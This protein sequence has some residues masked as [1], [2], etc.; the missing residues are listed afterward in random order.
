MPSRRVVVGT[1]Y[2]LAMALVAAVAAWPIYRS[3]EYVAVAAAGTLLG[4]AIALAAA[5]LR[6]RGWLTALVT[7]AALLVSGVVLAVPAQRG[8]LAQV[9]AA[10]RD[11]LLGTVTGF[12]DLI[13]VELPVGSYRNLLVPALVVFL[14]GTVSALLLSWHRARIAVTGALVALAMVFF[15]LAFGRTETSAPFVWGWLVVPAPVEL[16]TGAAAIVLSV[17][18]LAW[19]ALDERRESLRRTAASTGVRVT[20]RRSASDL[21]RTALAVGMVAVAVVL[22]GIAAPA[23][24]AGQTRQVLRSGVG[25]ELDIARAP[26]PL[27]TY[28][29]NFEDP[30]YDQVLFRVESVDGP[31]PDRVRL[32]TMTAYDGAVY[33][34]LDGGSS[35]ADARFVR[36]PSRLDPGTGV[37]STVRVTID[38]LRGI[39]LPTVGRISSVAFE[40]TDAAQLA[41]GFYY[42]QGSAAAVE[43]SGGGVGAGDEYVVSAVAPHTPS[44]AAISAPGASGSAVAAPASLV[45]WVKQQ[46]V[47]TD[48]AALAELLARLRER[49]YL[50]HALAVADGDPPQWVTDL[51]EYAFRPSASGHSLARV[52]ALFRALLERAAQVQADGGRGSLVAAVGDDEQFAVAGALIAEQ[53]GFPARVVLGAR[54]SGDPQAGAMCQDGACRAGDLTAWIEVQASTGQ[55][56]AADVTPQHTEG[57]DTA[58]RRQRDPENPT[59]VR[60]E[61]AAEVV[62]PQPEQQDSGD[63]PHDGTGVDLS[64]LWATLRVGG[65]ALA[66]LALVL[67]PLA[68]V[69]AAKA[70]RRRARR[71]ESD[72]ASRVAGGWEEYVDA[73]VDHGLPAPRALTR[74]ELAEAHARPA[75]AGLAATADRAV[76]SDGPMSAQEADEFWRI[77]DAERRGLAAEVPV[78]RRLAA[79]VSLKSFTR[80]L[81]SRTGRG[82]AAAR[83]TERRR[84]RHDDAEQS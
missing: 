58:V 10:A 24:A 72:P 32:A 39:W 57:I 79:A 18:S 73:A 71:G 8:S 34:V 46:G 7:A 35:V 76:F 40:G 77:V 61:S 11:V 50:S 69:V 83:P 62:P 41:D 33:R 65:L 60:P 45:E 48:G 14:V 67:G 55:W 66:V 68:V 42:N 70:W 74:G 29:A 25:P 54:L 81:P 64:A 30:R 78:W 9:P 75:A 59:D 22:G 15:G 31:L 13:T 19:L 52:D 16:A 4:V 2:V 44:L 12:K 17:G 28:R 1:L 3:G 38:G 37:A 80:S 43:T 23:L 21:R 84:R 53:L 82:R 56:V 20:R 47:G 6:W 36:V 26:A 49:G 5:L 27:S 51:G 63:A